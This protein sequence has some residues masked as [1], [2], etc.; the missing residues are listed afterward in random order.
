MSV[1]L[2]VAAVFRVLLPLTLTAACVLRFNGF[3]LVYLLLLLLLPLLPE[4]SS[5]SAGRAGHC[6]TAACVCSFSFLLLQSLF[7]L[8]N[9]LTSS[10]QLTN[11]TCAS[12]QRGVA[13]LGLVSL[14]GS[15]AGSAV[16]QLLPDV[17]VLVVGLLTWRLI[18]RLNRDANAQPQQEEPQVLEEELEEA[19]EEGLEEEQTDSRMRLVAQLEFLLCKGRQMLSDMMKT[20]GKVSADGPAGGHRHHV[21]IPLL[22]ALP[23]VFPGA[24]YLVGMG[25]TG[26]S[27]SFQRCFHDVNGLLFLPLP[28]HLLLPAALAAG[29]VASKLYVCQCVWPGL[30]GLAGLRCP[31]EVASEL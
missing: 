8:T 6:V 2:L 15:D 19:L 4:P 31:L 10:S 23:L 21:S 16:R 5:S 12:W 9:Q 13:Q 17:G 7:Q 28:A 29:G 25:R 14:T 20:G 27:P 22:H 11:L 3:S 26:P 18:G 1:D 24:V 30:T